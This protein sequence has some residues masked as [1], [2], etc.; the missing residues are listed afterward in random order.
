MREN[1]LQDLKRNLRCLVARDRVEKPAVDSLRAIGSVMHALFKWA[2]VTPDNIA[3]IYND[4]PVTYAEFTG[5]IATIHHYLLE[6][7]LLQGQTAIVVINNLLDAW[8]VTLALRAIG[9][10]TVCVKSLA[11]AETLKLDNVG[12]IVTIEGQ[13]AAPATDSGAWP[14]A[15]WLVLPGPLYFPNELF[16]AE[17]V[18]TS[19]PQGAHILYTSGTTGVY[20]KLFFPAALQEASHTASP[21]AYTPESR[22][23]CGGFGLWTGVGFKTPPRL[24]HCGG[25][26]I[27]DQRDDWYRY[28]LDS[29]VTHALL[30]PEMANRLLEWCEGMAPSASKRNFSLA[31]GGGVLSALKFERILNRVTDQLVHVFGITEITNIALTATVNTAEDTVYLYPIKGRTV[32]VVDE[33]DNL[34]PTG[35]EGYLRILLLEHDFC[36]YM[37]DPE[38]SARFFKNGFFYPGD[39]ALAG[40]D[41][42]IRPLGRKVDVINVGGAKLASAPIELDLQNTLKVDTV[43]LFS[44]IDDAG[45]EEL[46]VAVKA[47]RMPSE[48]VLIQASDQLQ[49]FQSVRFAFAR[50]FPLTTTGTQKVDRVELRRRLF[51]AEG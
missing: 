34:C 50:E 4:R 42:S 14:H 40:S 27:F 35:Q 5:A 7:G 41:G 46:V 39:M 28:F 37:G 48:S 25:C 45:Q 12:C 21:L 43:C 31:I 9:L 11:V 51:P 8:A 32:Q 23:H 1:I 26:A 30:I 17:L 6:K 44:G 24:W 19:I 16:A 15:R 22:Y 3:A 13:A 33:N 47:N 10:N 49:M 36:G 2:E 29:G 38:A 18:A 20:K